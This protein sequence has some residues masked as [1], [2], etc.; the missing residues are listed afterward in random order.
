[1]LYT[2]SKVLLLNG[3]PEK[4]KRTLKDTMSLLKK[5]RKCFSIRFTNLVMQSEEMSS[6][7]LCLAIHCR[8]EFCW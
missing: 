6:V 5:R 2:T 7:S 1:M 4:R 8:S 3:M